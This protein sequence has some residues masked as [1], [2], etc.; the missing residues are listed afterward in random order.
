MWRVHQVLR[1]WPYEVYTPFVAI[2]VCQLPLFLTANCTLCA[3]AID[4]APVLYFFY[5]SVTNLLRNIAVLEGVE[6][7]TYFV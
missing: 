1:V 4:T 2:V 6:Q 5:I 3:K 7:I